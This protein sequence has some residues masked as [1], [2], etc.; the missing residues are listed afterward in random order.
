[1]NKKCCMGNC[2]APAVWT[3]DFSEDGS[4]VYGYCTKHYD[5]RVKGLWDNE[6]YRVL[7]VNRL[8]TR[9]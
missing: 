7:K 1:M 8:L 9:G 3:L 2:E 4:G 6:Q 5:W